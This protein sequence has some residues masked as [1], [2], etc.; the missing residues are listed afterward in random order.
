L[1]ITVKGDD[2]AP[3]HA[4]AS[5]SVLFDVGHGND[6]PIS[7]RGDPTAWLGWEDSN[8][9]TLFLQSPWNLGRILIGLRGISGRE[10]CRARAA[11]R[12]TCTFG[13]TGFA[14]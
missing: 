3:A 14:W 8:L 13:G 11:S 9:Q 7:A 12:L 6:A 1:D 5:S 10:T 2:L 4:P